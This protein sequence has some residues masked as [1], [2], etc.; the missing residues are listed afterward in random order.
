MKRSE[1]VKRLSQVISKK[2]TGHYSYNEKDHAEEVLNFLE[3]LKIIKPTHT[4]TIMRRD[5][6]AMPYEDIVIVKGWQD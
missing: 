5:I 6:E 3:N 4:K 2:N 1:F